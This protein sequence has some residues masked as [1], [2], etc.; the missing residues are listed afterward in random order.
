MH[1]KIFHSVNSGLYL[2]DGHSHLLI[3]SIHRGETVGFSPMPNSPIIPK[4]LLFTHSH[5]DHF[6]PQKVS[7]FV[8]N[9]AIYCP[10]YPLNNIS[11]IPLM[12]NL[13]LIKMDDF[14]ILS[15]HSIHDC[16]QFA[17]VPHRSYF[18][19]LDNETIF[20]AGDAAFQK[21]DAD[22]FLSLEPNGV[23]VAFVN[24]YQIAHTGSQEFLRKI[25]PDRVFLYHLPFP[26]D[27]VFQIHTS[28]RSALKKYPA[29]LPMPVILRHI[30]WID[31]IPPT[32]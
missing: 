26:E 2:T 8:G 15:L 22:T 4:N 20:V 16:P 31:N 29:D 32:K 28:M 1:L 14:L 13:D 12:K 9:T 23:D 25:N 21:N 6:D 18:I 24:L 27:D 30:S 5:P 7:L 3:D 10:D 11:E 19:Q 17:S